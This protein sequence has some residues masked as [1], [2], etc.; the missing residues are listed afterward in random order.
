MNVDPVEQRARHSR[1]VPFHCLWRA[2]TAVGLIGSRAASRLLESLL[3]QVSPGDPRTLLTA[4]VVLASVA[5]MATFVPAYR[6]TR[7]DAATVM[8]AE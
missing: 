3:F 1:E 4:G 6:A 8:R 7:L 2:R 5:A